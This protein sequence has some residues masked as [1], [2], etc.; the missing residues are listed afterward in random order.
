MKKNRRIERPKYPALI[1]ID[2]HETLAFIEAASVR[3]Q[4]DE[5]EKLLP[6]QQQARK[7]FGG[8]NHD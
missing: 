5:F 2:P 3:A 1:V 7:H 8:L 4:N 6:R